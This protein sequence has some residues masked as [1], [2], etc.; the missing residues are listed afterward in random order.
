MTVLLFIACWMVVSEATFQIIKV[1]PG[2]T[3]EIEPP[4]VEGPP[5]TSS[6]MGAASHSMGRASPMLGSGGES[7]MGG[8]MPMMSMPQSVPGMMGQPM[9]MMP[10][11]AMG[12]TRGHMGMMGP[13]PESMMGPAM[14]PM[15]RSMPPMTM[16]GILT[17][18]MRVTPPPMMPGGQSMPPPEEPCSCAVQCCSLPTE[19]RRHLPILHLP[20]VIHDGCCGCINCPPS[21]FPDVAQ[22]LMLIQTTK[23]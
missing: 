7:M 6:P 1:P 19:P 16:E 13:M 8:A 21:L 20:N 12:M 11:R 3:V 9:E 17:V 15:P 4:E 2:A 10:D 18:M 14:E 23:M 22:M 5:P